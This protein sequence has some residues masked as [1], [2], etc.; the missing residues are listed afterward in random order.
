TTCP[1]AREVEHQFLADCTYRS[2]G[3]VVPTLVIADYEVAD[4]AA[5][6]VHFLHGHD[7]SATNYADAAEKA[8]PFITEW[9]GAPRNK[10]QTADL[11]DPHA[12][13]F[14][15]GSLLLTPMTGTD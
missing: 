15:S 4:R 6:E 5:I 13:P 11:A 14:E 10:A 2:L 3:L 12:P 8:A 1:T 9:F 7:A